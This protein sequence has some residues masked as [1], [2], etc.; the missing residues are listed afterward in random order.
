M[1]DL[2]IDSDTLGCRSRTRVI[3]WPFLEEDTNPH[4]SALFRKESAYLERE[5]WPSRGILKH[6]CESPAGTDERSV[7]GG[8]KAPIPIPFSTLVHAPLC[9]PLLP[10]AP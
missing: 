7:R 6:S 9:L 3:S 8:L 1:S 10:S 2:N 4:F 5:T